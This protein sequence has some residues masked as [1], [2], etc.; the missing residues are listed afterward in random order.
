MTDVFIRRLQEFDD[1]EKADFAGLSDAQDHSM[2]VRSAFD[3]PTSQRA[4]LQD[5]INRAFSTEVELKFETIPDVISGIE[6]TSKR[7]EDFVEHRGIL[8]VDGTTHW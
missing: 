1:D 5:A 4:T 8:V 7:A 6:L 2:I 3:L